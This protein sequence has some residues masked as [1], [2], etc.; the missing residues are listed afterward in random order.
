[1][2]HLRSV[3]KITPDALD[4]FNCSILMSC[5]NYELCDFAYC[6]RFPRWTDYE[7]YNE[8]IHDFKYNYKTAV[9]YSDIVVPL[10]TEEV[11]EIKKSGTCTQK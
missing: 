3:S 8:Q 7:F 1:M 11:K 9:F 10:H 6:F 5:S 2:P 4:M